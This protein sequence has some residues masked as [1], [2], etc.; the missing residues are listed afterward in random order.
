MRRLVLALAALGVMAAPAGAELQG[1][2]SVLAQGQGT[3]AT[4]ADLAANQI[5]GE[6]PPPFVN[7]QELYTGIAQAYPTLKRADLDRFYKDADPGAM[8]GG[9]ASTET[10]RP[11]VT[12]VRDATFNIPRIEV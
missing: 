5:S 10:P 2:R 8:P 6:V 7:Q 3:T 12:I 1:F 4:A 11:G 9:A